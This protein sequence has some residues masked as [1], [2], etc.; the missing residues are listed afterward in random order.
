MY[1]HVELFL[2][3]Q[4]TPT[5]PLHTVAVRPLLSGKVESGWEKLFSIA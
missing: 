3:K 5:Q 2:H 4:I 1:V